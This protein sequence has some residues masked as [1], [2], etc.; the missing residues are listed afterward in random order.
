MCKDLVV[1]ARQ[2]HVIQ[3]SA[4]RRQRITYNADAGLHSELGKI[5]L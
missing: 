2:H 5:G 4:Y 1:V 3:I